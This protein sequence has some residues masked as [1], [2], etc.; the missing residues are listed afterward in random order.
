MRATVSDWV[1]SGH[2]ESWGGMA[3]LPRGAELHIAN[4]I[5]EFAIASPAAVAVIDGDQQ[6]TYAA[7][8]QRSSR[9]ANNLL[10]AGLERG[11]HVAFLSGNRLEYCEVAAGIAKAGMAMVPLNPRSSSP[12][13]DF[14]VGHSDAKAMIMDDAFAGSAAGPLESHNLDLVLSIG[15]TTAGMDYEEALASAPAT[16]PRVPVEETEPFA[17]AYTSGTTGNP[18]GV[19]I[20]HRSRCLTFYVAALE[21]GVGMGRRS[22]AVAPLYHGAGFAFGYAPVHTGGTVSMLRAFDPEALL[23]MIQRDR[24]QSIF[25][26]PTHAALLRTLGEA[27]IR[28][29]DTSSLEVLYF[30][31]AALPQELKEWVHGMFPDVG[32]HELY[33]STEGAI[34]TDLRPKDIMR[35]ER[36]VGPPWF[37]TDV[38]VVDDD[39]VQV[40]PGEIGELYSRSPY[41]MN[42]YYKNPEAT[43]EATTSDG[44]FSAGDLAMV[45]DEDFVYIVDRRKD[46]IISGGTNVYPRD[47]EEVLLRHPAVADVAV[48]GLPSDRWGEQVTAVVVAAI[49]GDLPTDDLTALCREQLAGY[50]IP[51]RYETIAVLPR[52]AGGKVLKRELRDRFTDQD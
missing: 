47:V 8:N 25:L 19:M 41:L 14:I 23:A 32:L 44:Y 15:G 13:I 42:G 33:G 11:D 20:S 16:D 3:I 48:I 38:R 2:I 36:C 34:V 46:L 6:Q 37:M 39:G 40:E 21:W 29:Y 30:N 4:G 10:V 52:N 9:L 31:A 24:A 50:K 17:I 28:S 5:R 18:K 7:L 22:I 26:V 27:T 43:E 49:D 35:K 45:D 51:K 1:F 12:E